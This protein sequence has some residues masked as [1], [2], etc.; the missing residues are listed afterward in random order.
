[1][2]RRTGGPPP[3]PGHD[4]PYA[5]EVKR[6]ALHLLALVVPFLMG[7]LGKPVSTAILIPCALVFLGADFLRARSAGFAAWI[8]RW[9]GFMMR[10]EERAVRPDAVVIN[11]A[12]W[13]L[14]TAAILTV[15]FP[16][17]IAVASFVMFMVADAAAALF[18]RRFGTHRW[19][20][21]PR[22][23]EGSM[24]FAITG[25]IIMLLFRDIV[26]WTG[27]VTAIVAAGAE[28]VRRPLN[29]NIRVPVVAAL[30]LFLLERFVLGLPVSLFH[31]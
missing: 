24:A 28:V 17:R 1:M 14:V 5:A 4:I 25:V 12:T 9:F 31:F 30:T 3:D 22:T 19:P 16:M 23:L 29:D 7:I 11:G 26:F 21:S 2:N 8:D 13:V 18:G 6:K 27:V 15:I 20:N 10:G